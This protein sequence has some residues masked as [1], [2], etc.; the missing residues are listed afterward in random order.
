MKRTSLLTFAASLSI[1]LT[2]AFTSCGGPVDP[3]NPVVNPPV[4]EYNKITDTGNSLI[5][6]KPLFTGQDG[7]WKDVKLTT[8][9]IQYTLARNEEGVYI[10][11][12]NLGDYQTAIITVKGNKL[13]SDEENIVVAQFEKTDTYYWKHAELET[14]TAESK[15]FSF[16]IPQGIYVDKIIF[17]NKN[18]G[19]WKGDFWLH[20]RCTVCCIR[21]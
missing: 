17:Q 6:E 11:I 16:D 2:T 13:K 1:F 7:D 9:E 19:G 18:D 12:D 14:V 21:G 15:S 10:K 3:A 5:I 4:S 8:N 20:R